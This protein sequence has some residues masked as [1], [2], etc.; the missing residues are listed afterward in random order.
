MTLDK[1]KS[2]ATEKWTHL[3]KYFSITNFLVQKVVPFNRGD[4]I[5]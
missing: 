3:Q 4:R 1:K 5:T 2:V